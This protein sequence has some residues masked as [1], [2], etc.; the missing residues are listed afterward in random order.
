MDL[1]KLLCHVKVTAD[2]G[3]PVSLPCRSAASSS[4]IVVQ[5]T[6]TD[7]DSEY[8]LLFRDGQFDVE[9]QNPSYQNRVDLVD[10]QMKDGN[11]S[12]VLKNLTTDDTGL[13]Q[14]QVQNE[15]DLDTELIR[16]IKLEVLSPENKN[17][18]TS[19]GS[20]GLI[21]GLISLAVVVVVV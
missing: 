2:P 19:D 15:G 16:T 18:G 21:V 13:Y 5:W 3:Q 12:L 6:R 4:V 14:C 11:V 7:L 1:I 8:V 10:R 17:G 9:N 20:T